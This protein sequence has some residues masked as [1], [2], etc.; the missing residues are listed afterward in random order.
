MLTTKQLSQQLGKLVSYRTI[1]G[2]TAENG[3]ALD[4]LESLISPKAVKQR[5]Q[6]GPAEILLVGNGNLLSPDVGYL[7]HLDVVAAE[8]EQFTLRLKGDIA[9]GR[10]VSDMK[11][12]IPIGLALLEDWLGKASELSFTLAITTDEE[13]GGANGARYLAEELHFSP[14]VLI[15]P[16]GG[17]NFVLSN[18]SKGVLHL[19]VDSQG[20]AAHGSR[21]W[22]GRN[23]LE[24]LCR[25]AN[26]LAAKYRRNNRRA[27]WGT[28]ATLGFL[29]G[30]ISTNQVC[31]QATLKVDLRF[32][33]TR[34]VADIKAE[35]EELANAVDPNLKV[36]VLAYGNP[37][38]TDL[39]HP[40]TKLLLRSLEAE[41]G[42]KI[43]SAGAYGASDARHFS[44]LEIPILV[45]K[46]D[47]GEIHSIKEWI[48]LDSCLKYYCGLQRFLRELAKEKGYNR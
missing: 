48:S 27:N 37:T 6:V 13:I 32:P 19:Q 16:D 44:A 22:Q 33:E 15:V 3:R 35:V 9:L 24:P 14:K 25:L 28:T 23:A 1:S 31:P 38:K 20:L 43:T 39:Q 41:V 17:D 36:S 4:Y 47:G 8:D 21:P 7:V 46:P 34:S 10:G 2:D 5:Q 29:Q 11:F 18:K 30:G 12:S 40:V 45:I 26:R 42:R